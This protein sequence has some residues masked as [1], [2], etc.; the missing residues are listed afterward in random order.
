[1]SPVLHESKQPVALLKEVGRVLKADGWITAIEWVKS[2][3]ADGPSP[4]QLIPRPQAVKLAQE[5]GLRII[6]QRDLNSYFYFVLL[7]KNKGSS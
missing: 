4:E 6:A 1:M 7:K 5:A 3:G 2:S